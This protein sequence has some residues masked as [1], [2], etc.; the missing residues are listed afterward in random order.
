MKSRKII[1]I[2]LVIVI[3]LLQISIIP[4]NNFVIAKDDT[5]EDFHYAQLDD[6]A[7]S[8]YSAL[9]EMYKEGSLK[10]GTATY[11]LKAHNKVTEEQ[12]SAYAKGD[13]T[14]TNS[15]NAARY[16]F[17][18]DHPEIFYVN[19]SR[20][21]LRVTGSGAYIGAGRHANYLV[22]GFTGEIKEGT[23][24]TDV[25]LAIEEFNTRVNEIIAGA[26]AAEVKEG[27]TKQ[28]SQIKY[29]HNEIINNVSYRIERYQVQKVDENGSPIEDNDGNP[30]YEPTD[31]NIC[32]GGNEGFLGTP[33][34]A[35]VKRQSVCE[36][37]ARAF[38]TVLDK[39]GIT[40][41]LVQGMHQYS[42]QIAVEHMW[43]YVKV[44]DS[45]A[46]QA[47]GKWYAVDCTQ[48]D[49]SVLVSHILDTQK[50]VQFLDNGASYGEDG[51]ENTKYL[52]AGGI[53]MNQRH[54]VNP[55]VEAAGSYKFEYPEL[56]DENFGTRSVEAGDGFKV[57][58]EPD[59]AGSGDA[60]SS[61]FTISYKGLGLAKLRE[62]G[63]YILLRYHDYKTSDGPQLYS[64]WL[65]VLHDVYKID[66]HDDYFTIYENS[67]KYL[68]FAVTDKKPGEL[69]NHPE[70]L[71]YKGQEADFIAR[72]EKLYNK[73]N[74]YLA[75]PFVL[76]QTPTATQTLIRRNK[77]YHVKVEWDENLQYEDGITKPTYEIQCTTPTGAGTSG[78]EYS[79][80]ENIKFDGKK[81]VEFDMTFSE[82]F[83]DDNINYNIY[84]KGLV[85]VYSKKAP[86]PALIGVANEIECPG[87]QERKGAWE[88]YAKPTLVANQD[89]SMEDWTMSNGTKVSD[90]LN[91]RITLVTTKTTS[92]QEEKMTEVREDKYKDDKVVTSETY[93]ISLS[94][95]RSNA[96]KTGHK[97]TMKVGFPTGYGP[98]SAGVTFKAYHFITD[99][100]GEV[101]GVEELDCIVTQYGLIITCDAYSPFEIAVVEGEPEENIKSVLVEQEEGGRITSE[102]FL[103]K[104]GN[105]ATLDSEGNILRLKENESKQ[106]TVTPDEGYEIETLTVCGREIELENKETATVE[107]NYEDVSNTNNIV[108][109]TYVEKSVSTN[110]GKAVMQKPEPAK[111][112]LKETDKIAGFNSTLTLDANVTSVATDNTYQWY[113]ANENGIEIAEGIKGIAVQGQANKTLS[114]K[115]A[116]NED[117]GTYYL[118]VTSIGEGSSSVAISDPCEVKIAR[119]DTQIE[120]ITEGEIY[121]D[122][123]FEVSLK[124]KNFENIENGLYALSGVLEYPENILT[125]IE[126][127]AITENGWIMEENAFNRENNKF[128]VERESHLNLIENEESAVLKIKFKV[129]EN[130]IEPNTII[131]V[132]N[133]E[134]TNAKLQDG[135]MTGMKIGSNDTSVDVTIN[136]KPATI[137]SDVYKIETGYISRI[138]ANSMVDTIKSNIKTG[139]EL[140]FIKNGAELSG[141]SIVGT[142]TVIKAGAVEYTAIIIGDINGDGLISITDLAKMR[143]HYIVMNGNTLTGNELKA[144]DIDG[145][146]GAGTIT[147]LGLLRQLYLTK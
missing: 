114:I 146:G 102:P 23:D 9:D 63:L 48:D 128:L 67:A 77:S 69:E 87:K 79:K 53:T 76:R 101:T 20:L 43:N 99:E 24:K 120:N 10:T 17:Y 91:N 111:V 138:P 86:R 32:Y 11:E 62:Q 71:R 59:A 37:Y 108:Y 78:A 89:L 29:V 95:C 68:E 49:P 123:E 90:I 39:L 115:N 57:T 97:V 13:R 25:E 73:N 5:G 143:A 121:P 83:A 38:K 14:L 28:I 88:I 4:F 30:V 125:P 7:K 118:V 15:M 61:L 19:F 124:V 139:Q 45:K 100:N 44:E 41:I 131:K 74:G 8:I 136:K 82:M 137:T 126:V 60:K 36:G 109:A 52:L 110:T 27:E 70:N 129:N 105:N 93:N 122:S 144:A 84:I 56:E 81:T 64:D 31:E 107:V 133:I 104:D 3:L 119:F 141:A 94:V 103:D 96:I 98:E 92:A 21:T 106:L 116:K 1:S 42:G 26:N 35:L 80:I 140:K 22:D 134:A 47:S 33:Y 58:Y 6:V 16:A 117:A 65:Y 50:Y 51:F 147:D 66:D 130:A 12:L 135:E 127:K 40:C 145:K 18:A 34:G 85:G 72:T 142:G 113:K 112:T 132:K 2:M 75:E 54:R 46:R 55:E